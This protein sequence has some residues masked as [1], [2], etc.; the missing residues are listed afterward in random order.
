MLKQAFQN[1]FLLTIKGSNEVEKKSKKEQKIIIEWAK[2][3]QAL[4]LLTSLSL[5]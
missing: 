5:F 1:Y 2:Y 4:S 3:K